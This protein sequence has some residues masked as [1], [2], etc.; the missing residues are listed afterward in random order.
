M[1]R[2]MWQH[3]LL[4]RCRILCPHVLY[5]KDHYSAF[6]LFSQKNLSEVFFFLIEL[7]FTILTPIPCIKVPENFTGEPTPN[8]LS[9]QDL[10]GPFG[11][12]WSPLGVYM[13]HFRYFSRSWACKFFL[14]LFS[15]SSCH[16]PLCSKLAQ[17]NIPN[18]IP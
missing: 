14:L 11:V 15:H 1:S 5:W 2:E 9:E 10:S 13:P 16:L 4:H 18:Q 3:P 7:P 17:E 8:Y 12:F 6:I